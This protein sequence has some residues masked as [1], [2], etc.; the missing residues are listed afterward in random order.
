MTDQLKLQP[1]DEKALD[2]IHSLYVR[3]FPL[4]ERKPFAVIRKML[5]AGTCD[6]WLL[7]CGGVPCG[8]ATVITLCG[9]ALLDYFAIDEAFRG[10]GLGG[11]ALG[12]LEAL[13]R[14]R[15]LFIEIECVDPRADNA[16][17]RLARRQF[18]LNHGFVES[19]ER[20]RLFGVDMEILSMHTPVSWATCRAV[21]RKIYRPFYLL[22]VRRLR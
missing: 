19:G 20:V 7:S 10:R 16:A 9:A 14:G 13:Y 12:Q 1:A 3:A 4:A 21:Y 18:Y 22:K 11:Q 17:Q 8:M 6:V 15:P 5:K 2:Y